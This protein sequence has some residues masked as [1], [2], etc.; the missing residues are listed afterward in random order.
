VG[1]AGLRNTRVG[2]DDAVELAYALAAEYRNRRMATK[3]AFERLGL[4]N[5]G[6]FTLPTSRT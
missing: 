6:C 3:L 2:G 1:R 4:T 5:I